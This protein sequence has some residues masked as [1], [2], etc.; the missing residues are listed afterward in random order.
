[1]KF[2][3]NHKKALCMCLALMLCLAL[4][5]PAFAESSGS[6]ISSA[7]STGLQ[8]VQQDALSLISTI[9]PYAL[10][11]MGAVL[12]VMIGIKVFKGVAKK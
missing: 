5:V 1:M 4:A 7:V 3:R 8:S 6:G 12:V 9:L 11:V 10:G 2:L